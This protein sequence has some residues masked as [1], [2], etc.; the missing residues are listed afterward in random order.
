MQSRISIA[1]LLCLLITILTVPWI[2][3]AQ[4]SGQPQL[5]IHEVPPPLQVTTSGGAVGL[6]LQPSFSILDAEGQVLMAFEIVDAAFEIEGESYTAVVQE[7]EVPWTIIYLVDTSKTLGGFST[8]PT[9]K[10]IKNILATS[11]EALP[12]NANI[13]VMSFA[14]GTSTQMEFNQDTEI[15]TTA[16]RNLTAS[17][18]GNSCMND[19]L[20]DAINKLGGAPGRKAVILLTA[21]TDDCARRTPAE[22]VDLALANRVQIYPVGLQGYTITGVELDALAEPTGGLAE[23]RDESGLAFGVSNAIGI[24]MNQWTAKATVYP[25][26]G[27]VTATL[28]VN[29]SDNISLTSR[30]FTFQ[31]SQDYIPPTEIVI[32]GNVQSLAEGILFNL[33]IR[34]REQIRQLNVTIVSNETGQSV[35]A[36]SLINFSEVNTVPTVSLISGSEYTLNLSAIDAGGNILSESSAEFEYAPPAA[37]LQVSDVMAPSPDQSGFLIDVTSQNISGVV[38]YAAWFGDEETQQIIEGT[39]VTI[40]LGDPILIPADGIGSGTYLVFVQALN[41]NGTV[42]AESPA[43]EFV[44]RK[45]SIFQTFPRAVSSSPLAISAITG[46]CC[47]SLIGIFA[48]FWVLVPRRK[49]ADVEVDLVLP[50]KERRKAVPAPPPAPRAKAPSEASEHEEEAAKQAEAPPRKPPTAPREAPSRKSPTREKPGP[51]PAAKIELRQPQG[52][53][54]AFEMR[55]SPLSIGRRNDNDAVLPLDSS[56]GVSG[57]HL[58]LTYVDGEYYATDQGSTYGTIVDGEPLTKGSRAA[59][60]DGSVIMLGPKVEI[61]FTLL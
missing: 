14:D 59:L 8:S 57:K 52:I 42:L 44:Y 26:A 19:G 41:E 60:K 11:V 54:F 50:Q 18:S 23:L 39:R 29:L 46:L 4:D 53:G 16:L 3:L 45:P 22:V 47:F 20:Y 55:S 13:A 10:N 15:A 27:D 32:K 34:Q 36:Q 7:N 17:Q 58:E 25:S 61:V 35:V 31:S 24:L 37:N 2:A 38:K 12:D 40:P 1:V 21:G 9:F 51:L 48:I 6:S 30:E 56:S 33:D 5:H 28:T 49:G 43:Y